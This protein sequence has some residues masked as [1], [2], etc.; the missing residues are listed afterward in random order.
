MLSAFFLVLA[1]AGII[2]Q[3]SAGSQNGA[4]SS[5]PNM[6]PV[7]FT[8]I[9]LQWGLLYYVWKAGLR[10]RGTTLRALIGGRWGG[11]KDVLIDLSLA[12]VLWVI[13]MTFQSV[14]TR[15][16]GSGHAASIQSLL[17]QQPAEV[18]LWVLL[19]IS[20]GFCEELIFRGYFLRQFASLTRST[21]LALLMQALLFGVSHGYQGLDSTV[22]ITIYGGLFGLLA[23][24]RRSLRPGIAAH[25]LTDILAIL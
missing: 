10:R 12:I 22:K 14:W 25:V 11:A 20:A 17:P 6:V 16:F 5:H 19:S 4:P 21:W 18:A 24:W 23:V 9:A 7:Y 8:L 2:F 3:R 15:L 1:L 13:W